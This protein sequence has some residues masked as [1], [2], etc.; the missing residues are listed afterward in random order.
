MN[1]D[2]DAFVEAIRE[3]PADALPRLVFA[4]WLEEQDRCDEANWLRADLRLAE[5]YPTSD[6]EDVRTVQTLKGPDGV[7]SLWLARSLSDISAVAAAMFLVIG[8]PILGFLRRL[9]GAAPPGEANVP[10]HIGSSGSSD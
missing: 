5:S 8:R 7:P 9:A 4:D 3:Q 1:V 10:S 2:H 6:P